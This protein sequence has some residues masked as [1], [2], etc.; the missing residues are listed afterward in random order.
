MTESMLTTRLSSVI[1]GCGGN[2]T[3]CSRRSSDGRSRSTNGTTSESPGVSVRWYRP[4]RSTTR[5]V[6]WGTMRTVRAS[7][8]STNSTTARETI[9]GIIRL[10]LLVDERGRAL[11]LHDFDSSARLHDLI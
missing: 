3:T 2:E 7:A 5:A 11:D 9:R 10:L 8:S 6:A 1:T 4:R